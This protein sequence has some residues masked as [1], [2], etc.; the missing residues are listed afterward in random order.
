MNL[1]V[2]GHL[3]GLLS[4]EGR[5]KS[6]T[7]NVTSCTQFDP[8][9]TTLKSAHIK[10][11]FKTNKIRYIRNEIIFF[12]QDTPRIISR[13][14]L[15]V[16]NVCVHYGFVWCTVR[17]AIVVVWSLVSTH[18]HF[19]VSCHF[20]PRA[21]PTSFYRPTFLGHGFTSYPSAFAV[22]LK[23]CLLSLRPN[24][25]PVRP[26]ASRLTCLPLSLPARMLLT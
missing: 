4:N 11:Q 16:Y 9:Y 6:S 25:M 22:C 15:Y 14:V 23:V 21:S 12:F 8:L 17:V 20:F 7:I 13:H 24:L 1:Q 5:S 26:P 18:T 19:P 3:L 2:P 10:S